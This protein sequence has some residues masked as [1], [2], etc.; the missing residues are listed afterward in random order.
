VIQV[1]S[2]HPQYRFAGSAP[3]DVS[4]ATNRSPYPTLHLI[5]EDSID[6][7]WP[8]SRRPRRSSRQH[9]HDAAPGA[10]AGRHCS[11][12]AAR[13]PPPPASRTGAESPGR[14]R[15]FADFRS[16]ARRAHRLVVADSVERSGCP[17]PLRS[18][19]HVEQAGMGTGAMVNSNN[20]DESPAIPWEEDAASRRHR[21][22]RTARRE[23]VPAVLRRRNQGP[24]ASAVAHDPHPAFAAGG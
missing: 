9:R 7:P 10:D 15:W 11:G 23:P 3:D 24:S 19:S 14:G 6:A 13:M 22:K 2:F 1:A 17:A 16:A 18:M 20:P 21:S 4:N 5:R 8:P 12:N